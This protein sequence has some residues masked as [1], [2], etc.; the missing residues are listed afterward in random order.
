MGGLCSKQ[1]QTSSGAIET[2]R[3]VNIVTYKST[4]DK[5]YE[6]QEGKY[7]YFRKINFYTL[8]SI[9]QVIMQPWKIPMKK[10]MLIIP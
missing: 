1:A 10:Q 6:F 2:E 4:A 7:N 9:F 8:W 3:E 5:T